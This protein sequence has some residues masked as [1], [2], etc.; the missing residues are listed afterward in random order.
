MFVYKYVCMYVCMCVCMYTMTY[1][2]LCQRKDTECSESLSWAPMDSTADSTT[3]CHRLLTATN[4]LQHT[5][6]HIMIKRSCMHTYIYTYIIHISYIRKRQS[7]LIKPIHRKGKRTTIYTNIH[8]HTYIHTYIHT[9]VSYR[10][11]FA[12]CCR[13]RQSEAQIQS[14]TAHTW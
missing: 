14:R 8:I 1:R 9:C 5:Y 11:V 13:A 2:S 3:C 10:F 4:P 12:A 6:I 7:I